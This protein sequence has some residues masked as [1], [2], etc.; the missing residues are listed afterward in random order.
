MGDLPDKILSNQTV[1]QNPA[2]MN[3]INALYFDAEKGEAKKG[4]GGDRAGSIR[5]FIYVTDQLAMTRDM[6][7]LADSQELLAI[8]PEEFKSFQST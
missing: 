8:L 1:S 2:L 5:R 6:F 3:A 4:S 7:D